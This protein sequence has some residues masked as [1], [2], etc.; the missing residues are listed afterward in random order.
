MDVTEPPVT[1]N[2][3]RTEVEFKLFEIE[4]QIKRKGLFRRFAIVAAAI[5]LSLGLATLA[6]VNSLIQPELRPSERD[7]INGIVGISILA[8]AG[9]ASGALIYLQTKIYALEGRDA[10]LRASKKSLIERA[11][12]DDIATLVVYQE[13]VV[14]V[15]RN[16]RASANH[17]RRVH[18]FFQTLIIIG[19]L[20]TTSVTSAASQV[21]AFRVIAPFV[22]I[23][24][25]IAAGLTGYFKFRERAMNLQQTADAIEHEHNAVELGIRRY[26]NL[27]RQEALIIFAE[28]V[29]RLKDEQRKREQQLDQPPEI[30]YRQQQA[31]E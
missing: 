14:E 26:R 28:E 22:S 3:D 8:I 2:M 9:A 7:L 5:S 10:K 11:S 6:A 1:L 13:S 16:Y 20:I 17:Y 29:E 31:S 24:V 12:S 19:A 23:I 18:N 27:P 25:G 21:S 30:G 4:E 15:I